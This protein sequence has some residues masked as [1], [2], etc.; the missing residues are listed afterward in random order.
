MTQQRSLYLIVLQLALQAH[1]DFP[2]LC[3]LLQRRLLLLLAPSLRRICRFGGAEVLLMQIV[4]PCARLQAC[5]L[6]GFTRE[7]LAYL[8]R[9]PLPR[10]PVAAAAMLPP[11][12]VL[13]S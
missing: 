12:H 6:P 7:S 2:L 3:L 10:V 9:C 8:C 11:W 5:A 13:S 4:N 1:G